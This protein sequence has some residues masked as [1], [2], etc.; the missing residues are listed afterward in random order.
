[1]S[2]RNAREKTIAGQAALLELAH[3][4][5]FVRDQDGRITS[6]NAG[7]ARTYGF[8][9][10]EALGRIAHDLLAPGSPSRSPAS[11]PP[12]PGV[13]SGRASLS[14]GAPTGRP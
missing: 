3:D 6:W 1:M 7:A 14:T 2:E 5:I 9:R 4:A 13:E 8:T 10:A 12:L 11:R